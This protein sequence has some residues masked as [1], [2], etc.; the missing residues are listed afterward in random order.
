MTTALP[1]LFR[2]F[3]VR[4][5]TFRNRVIVSPMC[6]YCSNEGF[7]NEWHLRHHARFALGGV[8]GAFVE[9]SGVTRNGRITPGCLGIWSD[10][11]IRGLKEIVSIYHRENIPVGMQLAHSGA[12]GSVST[13]FEKNPDDAN[14]PLFMVR[15]NDAWHA[16]GPSAVT[17]I[18]GYPLPQALGPSQIDEL[19]AAFV[20]AARRAL[21]AGFDLIEL[22]GAHGYLLNEFFSPLTN[23]RSDEWGGDLANR[24]RFPLKVAEAVRSVMPA[25]MP[26]FYR[27]SV[28]DGVEG[29]V[30][31]ADSIAL[32]RELKARGVDVIDCSAGGI[33]GPS[34][35]GAFPMAPG[36]LLPYAA[37]IRSEANVATMAVGMIDTPSLANA[38]I[39]RGDAD[40]V[41]MGRGLMAD[42]NFPYHAALELGHP[43]PHDVLPLEYSFYLKRK[44]ALLKTT[45]ATPR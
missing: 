6:Q 36:Y 44:A 39:E 8:G 23:Q 17:L 32:A 1:A 4:G 25:E 38:A 13:P 26:L 20:A 28:E 27:T 15:P 24:M 10:D 40:L 18:P 5:L 30:R 45:P 14:K 37:A 31:L 12:K 34:G 42:P 21:H 7:V 41:A 3:K 2:P 29:G 11:H 43:E 16:C 22:H 19:I 9:A 33:N 35:R